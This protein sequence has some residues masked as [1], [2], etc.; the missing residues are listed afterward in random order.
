MDISGAIAKAAIIFPL[1]LFA[2]CFH[3]F[4][5]GWEAQRRGDNTA[6]LMGRLTLNPIAHMD[7]VGTLV[8][9]L[10]GLMGGLPFI[11]GWAKPV[12]VN[13]RNLDNTV[14]DMFWI[15]AAGP[16]SN[17]LLAILSSFLLVA[18]THMAVSQMVCMALL[19][20]GMINI[21][22]AV[23]NM[24]P[25]HPLDGGK[26]LAR[27][28]PARWNDALESNPVVNMFILLALVMTGVTGLLI[29][30]VARPYFILLWTFGVDVNGLVNALVTL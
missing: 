26:I 4:A 6:Q 12:P 2:L 19:A 30:W 7:I 1:F 5:H 9:P 23:F 16:L 3:E 10:L 20:F 28:I 25:L 15:A 18:L 24:I 14:R 21:V 22:L 11:F 17:V 13:P 29:D 27:F 8:L